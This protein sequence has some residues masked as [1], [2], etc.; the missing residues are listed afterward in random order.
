MTADHRSG[1]V[2]SSVRSER[3]LKAAATRALFAELWES[4]ITKQSELVLRLGHSRRN[5]QRLSE[6]WKSGKMAEKIATDRVLARAESGEVDGPGGAADLQALPPPPP[7]AVVED[8]GP[9]FDHMSVVRRILA[10]ERSDPRDRIRAAEVAER[11]R[12]FDLKEGINAG[13]K[14]L[15]LEDWLELKLEDIPQAA[16]ARTFGLLAEEMAHARTPWMTQAETTQGQVEVYHLLGLQVPAEEAAE[17]LVMMAPARASALARAAE[18][19]AL[20]AGP[21]PDAEP[22]DAEEYLTHVP[23]AERTELQERVRALTTRR[24][25]G[26]GGTAE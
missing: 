9:G 7:L 15:R 18:L 14:N 20:R 26:E 2:V 13:A 16:R 5:I 10:S 25:P 6:E 24:E 22:V 17:L 19:A 11:R 4:G 1:R 21:P 12:Q 8:P 3:E 23:G